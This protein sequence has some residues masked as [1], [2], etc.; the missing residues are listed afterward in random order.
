[1]AE[2]K[3]PKKK[4]E[5]APPP[6]AP[7]STGGSWKEPAPGGKGGGETPGKRGKE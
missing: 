7:E 5:D 3:T 2:K 6:E 4:T 1:M